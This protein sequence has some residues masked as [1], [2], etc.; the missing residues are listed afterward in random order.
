MASENFTAADGTIAGLDLL[1]NSSFVGADEDRLSLPPCPGRDGIRVSC[2][3]SPGSQFTNPTPLQAEKHPSEL[4]AYIGCDRGGGGGG[5]GE[6]NHTN[7]GGKKNGAIKKKKLKR[8]D[9]RQ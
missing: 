9:V 4:Y 2:P 5:G 1:S 8:L 7:A 6:N 3:R